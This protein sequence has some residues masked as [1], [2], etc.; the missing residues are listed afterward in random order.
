MENIVVRRLSADASD[1]RKFPI[2]RTL[3]KFRE[4]DVPTICSTVDVSEL[5]VNQ[6]LW[7]MVARQEAA[8]AAGDNTDERFTLT[9]KGWGEYIDALGSL[10]ELPE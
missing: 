5:D 2:M 8:A 3:A 4:C 10:Y 1:P 9:A 6:I 7:D